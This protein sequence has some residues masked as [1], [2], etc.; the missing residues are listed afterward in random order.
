MLIASGANIGSG[1][2]R[3]RGPDLPPVAGPPAQEPFTGYPQLVR[4]VVVLV[5]VPLQLPE[6]G[7]PLPEAAGRL[8]RTGQVEIGPGLAD[9]EF[10]RIE[11]EYGFEFADD[12]RAFLQAGLPLNSQPPGPGQT[13]AKPWPDWRGGD[14][15]E[16][17]LQLD[18]PI[19]GLLFD[20]ERD[21]LWHPTWGSR[22][23]D[24]DEALETARLHLAQ[25]PSGG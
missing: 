2:G 11:R 15:E 16:L 24:P 12:H 6:V 1:T 18:W 17:R 14:P 5:V 7:H 20:V 23:S 19:A 9:A 21:A 22:P 25:A 8:A 13:W 3:E 10:T 4:A